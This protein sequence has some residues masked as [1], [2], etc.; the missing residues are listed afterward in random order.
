MEARLQNPV[1]TTEPTPKTE[2]LLAEVKEMIRL[3]EE[4]TIERAKAA[5]RAIRSHPYQTL[6]VA[7]A[8]ALGLGLTIGFFARRKPA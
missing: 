2:K 7:V 6:G 8:L 1:L 3:A 5:D 4:K